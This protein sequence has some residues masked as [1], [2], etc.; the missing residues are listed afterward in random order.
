MLNTIIIMKKNI[1]LIMALVLVTF[2]QG[3]LCQD[4]LTNSAVVK[5]SKAGLSDEIINDM[6][7]TSA[8]NFDLGDAAVKN[9]SGQGVS[10][11]VIQTMK[12]R[13][14]KAEPVQ[15]TTE[16]VPAMEVPVEPVQ[17]AATEATPV[18][19]Q[20]FTIEALNYV[21]PVTGIVK[22]NESEFNSMESIIAEWDKQIRGYV[23]DVEKV[24]SQMLQLEGEIRVLKNADSRAFGADI[25]SLK[26]KLDA[27]RKNYRQSKDIMLKAGA[28]ITKKIESLGADRL[29][30]IGKAYSEA[31]QGIGS[32]N[33]NPVAGVNPVRVE[34]TKKPVTG[35]TVGYIVYMNEMLA[36]YQ[37]DVI[38]INTLI[39]D[40]NPRVREVINQDIEM[41]GRL[42][43][44]QS[45]L[46]ELQK[47]P[48]V[49]KNEISSLK[50]QISDIE[51]LRK[52]LASK[53]KDDS[54][55]L[56][57]YLKDMNQ[58][59]QEAVKQ[60]FDDIIGNINYAFQEKLSL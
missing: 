37:N 26:K 8:V 24:K 49:N 45:R 57:D 36:W 17:Q 21:G 10:P 15:S 30:S 47:D 48:K 43:P 50:K 25:E 9:L 38:V 2:T 53:M 4:V 32:S 22:F 39:R 60:R 33:T 31:I 46:N 42:E 16:S 1:A 29:K 3:A 28:D 52:Q 35:K 7:S 13:G 12:A 59:N 27:Y 18:P 44:L 23:A 34:Y 20:K 41:R 5:M 11:S 55:E 19:A 54:R 14:A 40:W 51:K 56:A 6:I 58:K